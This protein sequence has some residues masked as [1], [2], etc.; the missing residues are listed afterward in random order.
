MILN[1]SK[2]IK[3][4]NHAHLEPSDIPY[5]PNHFLDRGFFYHF[6]QQRGSSFLRNFNSEKNNLG[7][8]LAKLVELNTPACRMTVTERQSNEKE[9]QDKI[10]E[11]SVIWLKKKHAIWLLVLN[12]DHF[13]GKMQSFIRFS[14][15]KIS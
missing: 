1:Y 10:I 4:V 3:G 2:M 5:S 12:L 7:L 11:W 14:Y 8:F 15:L 6:L 13:H 9:N